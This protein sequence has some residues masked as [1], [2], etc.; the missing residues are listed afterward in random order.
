MAITAAMTVS[1]ATPKSEQRVA[2]TCT[3]T[4]SGSVAVNIVSITPILV[5]TGG[6]RQDVSAAIGVPPLGGAFPVSVAGS[7]GTRAVTFDVV[8]HAPITSYNIGAEPSSLVYDVGAEVLTSDGA[9]TR[10]TT[11][12]LTVAYPAT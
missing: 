6:T 2:C 9:L 3:V 1:N 8:A 10:A 11:T 7:S 4:N 12:T 5:P